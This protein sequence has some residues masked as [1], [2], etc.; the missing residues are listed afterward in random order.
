[1]AVPAGTFSHVLETQETTPL[2]PQAKESKYYAAGVGLIQNGD[3]KL[4]KYGR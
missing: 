4:V 1:M 2:E 3:L